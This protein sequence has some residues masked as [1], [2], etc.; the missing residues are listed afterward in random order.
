MSIIANI[1]DGQTYNLGSDGKEEKVMFS[2]QTQLMPEGSQV[3]LQ[4][5][6]NTA[7]NLT[8]NQIEDYIKEYHLTPKDI[9]QCSAEYDALQKASPNSKVTL[10]M[11]TKFSQV[12]SSKHPLVQ[13]SILEAC[14]LKPKTS[15]V[16][17]PV[18]LKLQQTLKYKT[19]P[20][21]DQVA[22]WMRILNPSRSEYI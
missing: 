15:Q 7:G 1:V 3:S 2:S 6:K 16:E 11:L 5:L 21:A 4:A 8:K 18:Y 9:F 14:G 20:L 19:L 13:R 22:W 17:W 10:Q 12:L